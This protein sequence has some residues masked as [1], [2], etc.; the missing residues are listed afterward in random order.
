MKQFAQAETHRNDWIDVS[1]PLHTGVVRWPGDPAVKIETVSDIE[2]GDSHT[3]SVISMGSHSGTHVDAPRH[4]IKGG[5]DISRMP[6]RVA[7]GRARVVEI[8]DAS[9]VRPEELVPLGLRRGERV[10]FK[11]RNSS[12]LWRT[13]DFAEDFVHLSDESAVFLASLRL[14]LVGIDYLSVG[15]FRTGGNFVHRALLSA[16]TWL[17]EGL[18]LSRAAPGRYDMVCLPL[19]IKDG[20]GAPARVILRRL[21]SRA[22]VSV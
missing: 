14:R 19:P 2:R 4:S 15:G 3:L 5:L 18:D 9:V 1:V 22:R 12:S 21:P 8:R 6:L 17:V 16:G 13:D 10:L 20:D 11:T 7:V